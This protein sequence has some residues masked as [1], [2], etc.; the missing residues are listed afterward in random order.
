MSS[1]KSDDAREVDRPG[2]LLASAHTQDTVSVA[3][4]SDPHLSSLDSVPMRDLLNKRALGYLSWRRHRRAEHRSEVLAAMVRDLDMTRPDHLVVT[5]DLTHLG[6]PREFQEA[7]QWLQSLG[8]PAQVTVIPGNH[9]AYVATAWDSTFAL[10]APYMISDAVGLHAGKELADARALFPSVR[11]RGPTALIGLSSARP[12]APFLAIGRVGQDQL[13][14]LQAVLAE[15]GRQRLF[16]ILLI[17]HPPVPGTVTGRKRLIDSA[18]LRSILARHGV[19]LV[20]HGHAHRT[21]LAALET[22]L[23]PVPVIGVPSTSAMGRKP[24][25]RA[26]YHLYRVVR[27]AEGWDLRI[28]VRGYCPTE[29]RFIAEGESHLRL[30]RANL[31]GLSATLHSPLL[32]AR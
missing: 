3:H 25:R 4:L 16:R 2:A 10:W 28:S 11:I 22:P 15:T 17:H 13:R 9:D 1:A 20:L 29:D 14:K 6:L 31:T 27:N 19:E 24:G 5:G 23:G 18:A 12:C 30:P 32:T 21:T 7:Q 8:P 26:R